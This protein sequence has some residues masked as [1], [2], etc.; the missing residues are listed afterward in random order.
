MHHQYEAH[1]N[2]QLIFKFIIHEYKYKKNGDETILNT[3]KKA[4]FF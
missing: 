2:Y 3:D 1:K 4:V